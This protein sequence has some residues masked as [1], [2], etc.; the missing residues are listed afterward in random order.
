[1]LTRVAIEN[2]ATVIVVSAIQVDAAM[3]SAI[4]FTSRLGTMWRQTWWEN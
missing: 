4:G 2:R 1:V 3:R